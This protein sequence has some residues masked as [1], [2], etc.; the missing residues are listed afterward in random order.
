MADS[1]DV[2]ALGLALLSGVAPSVATKVPADRPAE[3]IR[4]SLTGGSGDGLFDDAQLLVECWAPSTVKAS[5]M[6]REA[7]NRLLDARFDVVQG[8]QV[9]GIDCAYPV[10]FP[11]ET[12]DRYQFP[13][14]VRVR[15]Y[16]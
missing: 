9:Y 11:D 12:S 14:T 3:F 2:E 4:L 8:W 10:Y 5:Q 13:C 6:A 7:R 16:N 15:R 1:P